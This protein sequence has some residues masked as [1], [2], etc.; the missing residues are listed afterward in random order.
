MEVAGASGGAGGD[1]GG[2][3]DDNQ[4]RKIITRYRSELGELDVKEINFIYDYLIL[5]SVFK[6]VFFVSEAADSRRQG[7]NDPASPIDRVSNNIFWDHSRRMS[8]VHLFRPVPGGGPVRRF[9]KCERPATFHDANV[10]V[11]IVQRHFDR[12]RQMFTHEYQAYNAIITM[13]PAKMPYV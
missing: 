9:M 12:I 4:A 2:G 5:Y 8:D 13:Y 1:D 7:L 6:E 3:G 11:Q 10:Y